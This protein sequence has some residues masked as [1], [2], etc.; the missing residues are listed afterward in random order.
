MREVGI[1]AAFALPSQGHC[2]HTIIAAFALYMPS[3]SILIV[4]APIVD[5]FPFLALVACQAGL[6]SCIWHSHQPAGPF[7]VTGS[8]HRRILGCDLQP[9]EVPESVELVGPRQLCGFSAV[10]A[11]SLTY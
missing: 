7:S 9:L 11:C 8:L 1:L 6:N 5:G 10:A 2:M 4:A 3:H